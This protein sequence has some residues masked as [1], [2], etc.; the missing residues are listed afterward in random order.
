MFQDMSK[1]LD[2]SMSPFK[3]LVDIQT[4]MLEQLTQQQMAC[5][6]ACIDATMQQTQALQECSSAEQLVE[7][8][9]AYASQL[10]A[11]LTVA[12][13]NNLKALADAQASVEKLAQDSFEAF[14]SKP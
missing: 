10:E 1:A 11:S 8:Q 4:K 6:K 12:N 3:E 2:Q 7:L 5:T 13:E 14:A 9:K